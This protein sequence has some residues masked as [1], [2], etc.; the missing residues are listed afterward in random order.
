MAL[1]LNDEF[2]P[3]AGDGGDHLEALRRILETGSPAEQQDALEKLVRL[4]AETTLVAS[5]ASKNPVAAQFAT[6]GL[7]ECWLNEQGAPARRRMEKG[8]AFMEAG[9]MPRAMEIFASL[10]EKYPTWAEAYNKQATALYLLGNARLSLKL[11]QAVVEMKPHHFGAWNGMAL[12]A[13][14]LEKW[15]V[16]LDAARKALS[17]QP[18]SQANLDIIQLAQARL[19]EG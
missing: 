8:I 19:A 17:I 10:I 13:A 1:R 14:K 16:A 18:T 11:C 15:Q 9:D 3:P 5:L 2:I 4:G 6:S 12:C 7:W